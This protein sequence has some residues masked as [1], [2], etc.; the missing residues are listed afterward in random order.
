[1]NLAVAF[2]ILVQFIFKLRWVSSNGKLLRRTSTV[3]VRD[4]Q[5]KLSTIARQSR[6]KIAVRFLDRSIW[7]DKDVAEQT[8]DEIE[9]CIS[10]SPAFRACDIEGR[11]LERD[12]M[13]CNVRAVAFH[14]FKDYRHQFEA[15]RSAN[16]RSN[17][18]VLPPCFPVELFA[19]DAT[20]G[21]R[22]IPLL[23]MLSGAPEEIRTPDP[24]IRSLVLYP[25]ELRALTG[26]PWI[27]DRG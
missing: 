9:D 17:A 13:G 20:K 25:A 5:A 26:L 19:G 8:L 10:S 3:D 18:P 4:L 24:Q 22:Q 21:E 15:S 27:Q 2:G 14:R 7:P 1:M 11:E 12:P 16:Q 6:L 23:V